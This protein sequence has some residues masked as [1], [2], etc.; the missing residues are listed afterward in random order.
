MVGYALFTWS[1]IVLL[2]PWM[3]SPDLLV[4]AVVYAAARALLRIRAGRATSRTFAGLG[5]AQFALPG[6][7]DRVRAEREPPEARRAVLLAAADPAQPYGAALTWPRREDERSGV[8]RGAGA[9]VVLVDGEADYA[10]NDPAGA[11]PNN[12]FLKNLTPFLNKIG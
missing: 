5:A 10:H 8:Q 2:V 11:S 7:V 3:E 12:E 4:A 6:A 9:Y 1:A